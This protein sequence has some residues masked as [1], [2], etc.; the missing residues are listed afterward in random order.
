MRPG[1]TIFLV[2]VLAIIGIQFVIQ[3][4]QSGLGIVK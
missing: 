1:R 2:L 3:M 4:K